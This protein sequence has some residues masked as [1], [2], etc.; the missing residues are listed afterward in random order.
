MQQK[1]PDEFFG[2]DGH[3]FHFVSVSIISPA[4]GDSPALQTDESV[5]GYCHP[6][7]IT[8]KICNDFLRGSKWRLAVYHPFLRVVGVQQCLIGIRQF[9]FQ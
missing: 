7:G 8:T 1:T 4:E 5:V 2:S 9:F 3:G 6:V